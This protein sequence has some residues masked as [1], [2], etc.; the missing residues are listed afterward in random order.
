V[1][2]SPFHPP[3]FYSASLHNK[4]FFAQ[5][6]WLRSESEKKY[7]PT[8]SWANAGTR[9]GAI[10]RSTGK[11]WFGDPSDS[12]GKGVSLDHFCDV[13]KICPTN[14]LN[15]HCRIYTDQTPDVRS[16]VGSIDF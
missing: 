12:I 2:E 15:Q 1:V 13:K 8:R 10:V 14:L 11:N 16:L 9:N 4:N 5:P 6:A 7:F 3:I